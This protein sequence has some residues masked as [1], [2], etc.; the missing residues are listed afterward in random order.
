MTVTF[1]VADAG[2]V[3]EVLNVPLEVDRKENTDDP[4]T[5]V[6]DVETRNPVPETFTTDP[7]APVAGLKDI[8]PDE[9]ASPG[10][11]PA[12]V[13]PSPATKAKVKTR[14]NLNKATGPRNRQCCR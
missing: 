7:A 2:I 6:P 4:A 12:T 14:K 3:I 5:T 9:A 1:P 13:S 10:W 11:T 8:W